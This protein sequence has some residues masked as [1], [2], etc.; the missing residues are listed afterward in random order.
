VKH[1]DR[2][3]KIICTIGPTCNTEEAITRLMMAGMDV[4]RLNFSHGTHDTHL[5]AIRT[6][7]RVSE[8]LGKPVAILQDLQGPKIRIGTF[9]N[10]SVKVVP[11]ERFS[12]ST[13][14]FVGDAT[15]VST[16]YLQLPH[17]VK[18]GSN[19]LLHDGLIKME[20]VEVASNEVTCLV[21]DGGVLYDRSGM[22]LPGTRI[23]EPCFTH[24]DMRDLAFGLDNG[25]DYVALSFVREPGDIETIRAYMGNRAVPVI[26]KLETTEALSNLREIIAVA[27]GIMVARGDL[28]VEISAARVPVVQKL[29]IELCHHAGI[30]VITATQ[31]LDS[32][33]TQPTPTR[34]EASDVANAVFDGSDAVMLSGETAFGEYPVK[35]VTTMAAI[36]REAEQTEY[37]RLGEPAMPPDRYVSAGAI[38]RAA[39]HTARSVD[40]RAI[41]AFTKSGL[42][43]RLMSKFRPRTPI[44]AFTPSES[45]MSRLAMCWGTVPMLMDF[46]KGIDQAMDE[47]LAHLAGEG[48]IDK[49]DKLVVI[50]GS[51]LESGSGINMLRIYTYA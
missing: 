51:H 47:V 49:G 2:K 44:F 35:S 41:V 14:E 1:L 15:H 7:R 29:A 48:W 20:V 45:T 32:M 4:A 23:S 21:V 37:F 6:V 36:I 42:S 22:S 26:A 30:S 39:L 9:A 33:M 50:A 12:I 28:G 17:D 43:A 34:A 13:R 40:A 46:H 10:G 16:P 31:M 24:K 18:P 27:D 8:T 5:D 3:A 25:V 11:G 19:I 38:C